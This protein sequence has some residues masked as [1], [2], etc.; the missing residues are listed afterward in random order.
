MA[1]TRRFPPADVYPILAF[2]AGTLPG[3]R[4]P[5]W[6][7]P[8]SYDMLSSP[9]RPPLPLDAHDSPNGPL[10]SNLASPEFQQWL[11]GAMVDFANATGAGGFSFDYTY[12]EENPPVASQYA[13][14]TSARSPR[15]RGSHVPHPP[16]ELHQGV[17]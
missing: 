7:V 14:V 10:R 12:F 5:A 6:I 1:V 2:L 3:G 17:P 15:G 9:T 13:Q 16:D 4:S 11:T 8:G